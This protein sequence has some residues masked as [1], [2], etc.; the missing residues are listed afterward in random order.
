MDLDASELL[1]CPGNKN[2]N[3]YM[4]LSGELTVHVES[5]DTPLLATMEVGACVGEMFIIEDR[6]PSAFV[7]ATQPTHLLVIHKNILWTW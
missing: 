3:V 6:D 5:I 2:E 1:L 4:I 7:L